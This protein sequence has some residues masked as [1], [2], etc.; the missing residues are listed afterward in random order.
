[1]WTLPGK[2]SGYHACSVVGTVHSRHDGR[3]VIGDKAHDGVS[4]GFV[5]FRDSFLDSDRPQWVRIAKMAL[6]YIDPFVSERYTIS[7]LLPLR[8]K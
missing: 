7:T 8:L 5:A 2:P 1:M 4:T 6:P 3:R